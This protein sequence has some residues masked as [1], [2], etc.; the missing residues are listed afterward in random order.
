MGLNE[1]ENITYQNWGETQVKPYQNGR[2]RLSE[3]FT[4]EIIS[5]LADITAL[6]LPEQAPGPSDLQIPHCHTVTGAELRKLPDCRK[7]SARYI[8]EH[9]IPSEKQESICS[10]V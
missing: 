5:D 4:V 9:L 1:N 3:K 8:T 2:N 6:I 10:T 7:P